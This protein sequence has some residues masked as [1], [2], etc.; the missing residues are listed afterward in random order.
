MRTALVVHPSVELYGAD[1]MLAES[2]AGLRDAGWRV[3]VAL[4]GTGPLV[5]LLDEAEV[6]V[7][8]APV[9][10]KALMSPVGVVRYGLAVLSSLPRVLRL[11]SRVRPDV[12]YVSTLTVPS[13][14]VAARLARR[15]VVCHVH[16][17]EESVP[18]PVRLALT[19]PLLLCSAVLANSRA[20]RDVLLADLPA[21]TARTSVVYNGVVGPTFSVS[22][23]D[24]LAGPVRLVLVGRVSPRKGTDVA[25]AAL[26]QLVAAGWDVTLD[27]VGGVFPGYE[28][29]EAEVRASARALGVEDRVRW[30]GES[31]TP[32]AALA[33]ADVALV[34]SRVEPFGNTAVEALLACRPVVASA[35]QGLTEIVSSG[36]NGELA[37]PGSADD[38]AAAVERVLGDWP[39]ALSRTAEGHADAVRRFSPARY[40][41]DVAASL[42]AL[43]R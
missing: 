30:C 41:A 26:A 4:P 9:L 39:A 29:F 18:R 27:L 38:L 23:R 20:S 1:K 16:E 25:V 3:V 15:P 34:P 8:A 5:P 13:W 7:V 31:P 24:A 19:A 6:V 21:L 40:R 11:L 12:V 17:A 33:A 36:V 42:A 10:R 32:W 14:L 2:V 22:P 43:L 35:T 37:A 28:W